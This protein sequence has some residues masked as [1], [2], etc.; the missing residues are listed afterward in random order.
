MKNTINKRSIY[1]LAA[2]LLATVAGIPVS[3][4]QRALSTASDNA[5]LSAR[6]A[7]GGALIVRDDSAGIAWGARVTPEFKSKAIQICDALGCE[8]GH[9]MSVIAFET[10]E[11]FSP[12]VRN[13]TSGATGLIQF[14]P[15]TALA[16]GTTVE[17]L[18]GMRAEEQLTWVETY[19]TPY[20]GKLA[21]ASD[22]YM[23]VIWP[24]AVGKPEEA[25]LFRQPS[26][27]YQQ[28]AG[29]DLDGDGSV[30]KGEATQKI[31]SMI[32]K[33]SNAGF[34]G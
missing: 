28:N 27:Q 20:R 21:T 2:L 34:R 13:E 23:A 33:G 16:L 19:L 24:R 17:K 12:T 9:L 11:R 25:V 18:A 31:E 6:S 15:R 7:D 4:A 8:P 5:T 32:I 26:V 1:S 29:L 3:Q 22:V 10:G 30:T 14:M